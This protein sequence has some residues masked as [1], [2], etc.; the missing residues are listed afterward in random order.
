MAGKLVKGLGQ[1]V[2]QVAGDYFRGNPLP[3]ERS[4]LSSALWFPAKFT[5]LPVATTLAADLSTRSRKDM[6]L[7]DSAS[8]QKM[9]NGFK[10]L[11]AD[12]G[13]TSAIGGTLGELGLAAK[14]KMQHDATPITRGR[15]LG[16]AFKGSGASVGAA[17]LMDA[18]LNAADRS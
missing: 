9:E 7:P 5:V 16:A 8:M 10:N 14:R 11:A 4:A 1:R 2:K 12:I 3:A 17:L 13:I 15:R 18:F 6:D